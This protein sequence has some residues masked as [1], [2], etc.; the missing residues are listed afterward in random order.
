MDGAG[1]LNGAAK[2]LGALVVGTDPVAVEATGFRLMKL[3]PE[4]PNSYLSLAHSKNLGLLKEP[5]IR[6]IGEPI[7]NLASE[8]KTESVAPQPTESAAPQPTESAA[9]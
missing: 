6:Q 1:P 4:T 2:P 7:A 3:N 9:P 8:F 5:Q